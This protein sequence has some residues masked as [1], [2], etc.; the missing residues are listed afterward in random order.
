MTGFKKI[1]IKETKKYKNNERTLK[2]IKEILKKSL[3][4][5]R[6]LKEI[7]SA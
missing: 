7:E 5:R 3:K 1:K 6:N 2:V 4:S